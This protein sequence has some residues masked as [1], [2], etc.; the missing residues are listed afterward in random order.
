MKCSVSK[1][2]RD[3]KARQEKAM[4]SEIYTAE[5]FEALKTLKKFKKIAPQY[6]FLGWRYIGHGYLIQK[7]W[8][9]PH[10]QNDGY[11]VFPLNRCELTKEGKIELPFLTRCTKWFGSLA[12]AKSWCEE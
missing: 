3:A 2:I 6:N 1:Q 8:Y 9:T 11:M 4:A 5:E 10:H 12:E 7:S